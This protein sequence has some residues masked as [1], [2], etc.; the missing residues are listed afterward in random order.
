MDRKIYILSENLR[1][2]TI[3][4]LQSSKYRISKDA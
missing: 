2:N 3:E 1:T 4:K